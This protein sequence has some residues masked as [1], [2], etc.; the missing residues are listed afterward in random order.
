MH[1]LLLSGLNVTISGVCTILCILVTGIVTRSVYRACLHPLASVP[2]PRLA[3]V[4]SLW[5]AY[6]VRNGHML[7]LGKTLHRQY[8]PVVRVR[9]NEVWFD[10]EDAF[11]LIYSMF[12]VSWAKSHEHD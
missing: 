1:P 12:T 3:G 7:T 10:S 6:H 4:T 11:R 8:G 2:G 9:P 5:Y